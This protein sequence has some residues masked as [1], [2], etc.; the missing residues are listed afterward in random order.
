[1]TADP[2]SRSICPL[3]VPNVLTPPHENDRALKAR[4]HRDSDRKAP[5]AE[6]ETASG[7]GVSLA[8][9]GWASSIFLIDWFPAPSWVGI[10]HREGHCEGVRRANDWRGGGAITPVI[11]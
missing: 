2:T 10:P 1:V 5:S 8:H 9:R 3:M 7:L 4:S 6:T 11:G